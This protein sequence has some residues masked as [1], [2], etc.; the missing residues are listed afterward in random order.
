VEGQLRASRRVDEYGAARTS[1][2]ASDPTS[3]MTT[4]DDAV[5][6]I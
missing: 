2:P 6:M 4:Y 3:A 5:L 1:Q